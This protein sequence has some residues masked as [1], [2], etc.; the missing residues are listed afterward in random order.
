MVS[1]K[2]K[3]DVSSYELHRHLASFFNQVA[4]IQPS[5]TKK[6]KKTAFIQSIPS[7]SI[8]VNKTYPFVSLLNKKFFILFFLSRPPTYLTQSPHFI[9]KNLSQQLNCPLNKKEVQIF[10][11]LRLQLF[12]RQFRLDLDRHLW[13]SYLELGSQEQYWPVSFCVSFFTR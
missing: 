5:A 10:V 4:I 1:N 3:R 7:N 13:Q 12:D 11:H 8:S 9:F 6:M 2:R